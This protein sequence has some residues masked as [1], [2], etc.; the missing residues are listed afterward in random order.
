MGAPTAA[1]IGAILAA[2]QA[3][4][5]GVKEKYL[6]ELCVQCPASVLRALLDCMVAGASAATLAHLAE[7]GPRTACASC[8]LPRGGRAHA[9]D[10]RGHPVQRLRAGMDVSGAGERGVLLVYRDLLRS[11]GGVQAAVVSALQHPSQLALPEWQE[12]YL[13]QAPGSGVELKGPADDAEGGGKKPGAGA[14]P[15]DGVQLAG[16]SSQVRSWR[17]I[18]GVPKAAAFAA[19]VDDLTD[20]LRACPS[21]QEPAP[22][23]SSSSD[24]AAALAAAPEA[25]NGPVTGVSPVRLPPAA[26]AADSAAEAPATSAPGIDPTRDTSV[27]GTLETP[28]SH[29]AP[30]ASLAGGAA[31]RSGAAGGAAAVAGTEASGTRVSAAEVGGQCQAAPGIDPTRDACATPTMETPLSHDAEVVGECQ[32][33]DDGARVPAA[34]GGVAG[35]SSEWG[36]D[37][38]VR[39]GVGP[40]DAIFTR[41]PGDPPNGSISRQE[42]AAAL[43]VRA[44]ERERA[45]ARASLHEP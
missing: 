35:D 28:L 33:D 7:V 21:E 4:T 24:A 43:L 26:D 29:D 10:T 18:S 14:A 40:F 41:M 30:A 1:P 20:A 9:C 13:E 25:T 42:F 34:G 11:P 5:A 17:I 19:S 22:H 6:L 31:A 12:E 23:K 38:S 15:A 45:S 37:P 32:A 2:K 3:G 39:R 8:V 16:S 27:T 36:G 44:R